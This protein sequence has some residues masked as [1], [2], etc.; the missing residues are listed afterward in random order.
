MRKAPVLL[1]I[2]IGAPALAIP[3]PDS[4]FAPRAV[5]GTTAALQPS[6]AGT[7]VYDRVATFQPSGGG[8]GTRGTVQIRVV[9]ENAGGRLDFYFKVTNA[10]TSPDPIK[11]VTVIG[12]PRV[13]YDVSWRIDGLGNV[14]PV[15]VSGA[16]GGT[17]PTWSLTYYFGTDAGGQRIM[18]GQSSKFLLIATGYHNFGASPTTWIRV[19]TAG[20]TY[21]VPILEP[22]P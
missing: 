19:K 15:Q 14:A 1:A 8:P 22:R 7:V 11:Q 10:A 2:A 16:T 18:P 5:P 6:L 13:P 9:R 21:T 20:G 4:D 3:V 17:P 12:F